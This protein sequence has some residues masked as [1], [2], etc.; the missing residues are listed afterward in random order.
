M[1]SFPSTK[2]LAG[3]ET[4]VGPC[5]KN[6]HNELSG[7]ITPHV[8]AIRLTVPRSLHRHVRV[9]MRYGWPSSHSRRKMRVYRAFWKDQRWNS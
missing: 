3:P 8:S 6:G 9:M 4:K 2:T 7:S 1:R 5:R